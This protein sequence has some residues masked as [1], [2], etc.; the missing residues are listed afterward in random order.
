MAR[1]VRLRKQLV[2]IAKSAIEHVGGARLVEAALVGRPLGPTRVWAVGKAAA[3]MAKG[4][5]RALGDDLVGGLCIAKRGS[6]SDS[7][8]GFVALEAG[9]PT[10]DPD[11]ERATRALFDDARACAPGER[12]LL[13]LS[14]G[15]SA[16]L[17]L[18]VDGIDLAT[19]A[20]ATRALL[21]GGA[22]IAEINAVRRRLGA[23]LGGRL[24]ARVPPDT[25][26]D[27]LALSD[28]A[29][30]D[31]ATIGSGP[32]SPDPTSL[33]VAQAIAARYRLSDRVVHALARAPALDRAD[34]CFQ[35]VRYRVI[36]R[37]AT[38]LKAAQAAVVTAGLQPVVREALVEGDVETVVASF[39]GDPP[40]AGQVVVAVGEPTVVVRGAGSGGR[41]QH[42][43]LLVG[44]AIAGRP[45][46][47]VACGSDGTDG[48]TVA[49]GGAVDGDS[50]ATGP[51]A[52]AAG[53]ALARFDSHPF[54]RRFGL[55]V[56]TGPTGTNLSDLFLFGCPA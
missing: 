35:R 41:A 17:A 32:V 20:E 27:V 46:A 26:I 40:R 25:P 31:P 33:A 28:V 37:P 19:V 36:A 8:R 9:H 23:A 24:A 13:L 30:D 49:A 50:F 52:A 18:P 3:Q 42:L 39:L 29:S 4:A 45:F 5:A 2:S 15:A 14:G 53:D 56:E 51:D 47:F 21:H 54:L 34:P 55:T 10:P 12:V 38:L 1:R 11:G 6:D 16:L 22:S 44:R 48:P 7:P 43:A